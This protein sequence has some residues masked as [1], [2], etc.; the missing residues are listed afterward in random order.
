VTAK[1][2]AG[3]WRELGRE[4]VSGDGSVR[5]D[6][7]RLSQIMYSADGYMSVVN[8]PK[9]RCVHA[10][11]PGAT[12]LD[13]LTAEQRAETARGVVAYAGRYEV[14]GDMVFHL[15]YTALNPTMIGV[16]QPR[17]ATIEG[18]DLTL[19]SLP[20]ANGNFFRIRWRRADKM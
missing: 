19:A 2:L 14:E 16:R 18:D 10:Q 1:D 3:A 11:E 13:S 9:A 12:T 4:F 5:P 17:R 15:I 7:P 6:V 20:D 8:A